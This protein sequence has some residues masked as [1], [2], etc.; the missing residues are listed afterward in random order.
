ML[1]IER[2]LS[3]IAQVIRDRVAIMVMRLEIAR[4]KVKNYDRLAE[5]VQG[6]RRALET[7]KRSLDDLHQ[8]MD[9]KEAQIKMLQN[10][11]AALQQ[12]QSQS[13]RASQAADR[14]DVFKR[15]QSIAVQ[16]PTLR[17][18]LADGGDLTARDVIDLLAPFDEMLRDFGFERIGEAG[19]QVP[20][21]PTRHRPVGRGARSISSTDVV[22][23]RYVGYL[24]RGEVVCKAEVAPVAQSELVA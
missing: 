20:F 19:A 7:Q 1:K 8:Q 5:T 17:A 24:Y 2:F 16:L 6:L 11:Y 9:D 15:L 18:A 14:L 10:E 4:L 23:V 22:R 13:G 21:D 12:S 3:A